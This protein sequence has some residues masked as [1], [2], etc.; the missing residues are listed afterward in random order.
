[1]L[2]HSNPEGLNVH[3]FHIE[4]PEEKVNTWLHPQK[5]VRFHII[6]NT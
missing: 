6:K 5:N 1:M 3:R 4:R 2:Q